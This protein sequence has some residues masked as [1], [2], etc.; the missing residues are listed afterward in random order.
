MAESY[1]N[2][3][4][5]SYCAG[6]PVNNKDSDGKWIETGWDLFNLG[7]DVKSA[8]NNFTNGNI[9][10][11]VIDV[12]AGVADAA[13]VVL[14][15][16]PGG[17]GAVLK[18]E[19][20][21]DKITDA[22][23]VSEKISEVPKV[24]DKVSD[25]EKVIGPKANGGH[26]HTPHGGV[27]H[28]SAINNAVD[29]AKFN[30]A[31]DIRKN[32]VQVDVNGNKVGLNRPDLQYNKDGNHYNVEFDNNK[33]QQQHHNRVVTQNDPNAINIFIYIGK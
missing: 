16:V 33:K 13:A 29:N 18:A 10:A 9:A 5:Y 22:T 26:T 4:P 24:A 25:V 32:Q 7:L 31:F 2:L 20:I 17:A 1:Y 23:K 6:D 28:G 11:G 14:P 30:G 8:Y 12:V 19:R 27:V 3:N 21:A 15:I